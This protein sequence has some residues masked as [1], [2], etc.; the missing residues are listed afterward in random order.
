[1]TVFLKTVTYSHF[2]LVLKCRNIATEIYN[3]YSKITHAH[4]EFGQVQYR[5]H[6]LHAKSPLPLKDRFSCDEK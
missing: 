5:L 1:M 6:E 2:F 4:F 3:D